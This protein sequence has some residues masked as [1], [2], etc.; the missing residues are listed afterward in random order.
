MNGFDFDNEGIEWICDG[1]CGDTLGRNSNVTMVTTANGEVIKAED[2]RVI[3]MEPQFPV[4]TEYLCFT[5]YQARYKTPLETLRTVLRVINN[6]VNHI[7]A[8]NPN[9]ATE[10]LS[11]LVLYIADT[12]P[13]VPQEEAI[14]G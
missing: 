7:E 14:S 2:G 9:A 3:D 10:K 11:E 5:C 4:E 8:D 1:P 12:L 6:V 13:K